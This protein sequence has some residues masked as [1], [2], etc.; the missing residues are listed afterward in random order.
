MLLTLA[1]AG[2]ALLARGQAWRTGSEQDFAQEKASFERYWE[3]RPVERGKGW[4]PFRRCEWFMAPRA[5]PDGRFDAG[6]L[7]A[8]WEGQAK[9]GA[10]L[11]GPVWR[12]TGAPQQPQ[13]TGSGRLN[14]VA[15]HPARPLTFWVG[16]ASGGAGRHDKRR[17]SPSSRTAR[18]SA[19]RTSILRARPRTG[20]RGD[21]MSEGMAMRCRG[22]GFGTCFF[23]WRK[24]TQ[25]ITTKGRK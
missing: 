7:L 5:Y 21:D 4:K 16:A 23:I 20:S 8:A 2:L 12:P 24:S 10:R 15:F 1:L 3:G 14:C 11:A 6:A 17:G 22:G 18:P 9:D 13:R 19:S 25:T